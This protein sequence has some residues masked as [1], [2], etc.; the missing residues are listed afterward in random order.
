MSSIYD[1]QFCGN[2]LVVSRTGCGK[3]TF[4]EK[5]GLNNSF[6][7]IVKTEWISGIEIDKKERLKSNLVLVTKQK[8]MW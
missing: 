8:F 1:G 2:I 4:L 7:D 5:L 6:S 3:T